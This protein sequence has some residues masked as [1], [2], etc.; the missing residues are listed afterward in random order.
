MSA[1]VLA[2]ATP[3]Y[4]VAN[5]SNSFNLRNIPPGDYTFHIW[6]EGVSQSFLEQKTRRVHFASGTVDLGQM[7]APILGTRGTSHTNKFGNPYPP[8][9]QSIY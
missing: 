3:L 5:S 9:P 6:I 7:G 1:V 2:L 8:D 4:A